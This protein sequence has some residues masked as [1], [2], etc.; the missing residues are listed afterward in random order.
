MEGK[1]DKLEN[2]VQKLLKMAQSRPQGAARYRGGNYQRERAPGRGGWDQREW[3][4][5]EECFACG[6][7]GH[8]TKDCMN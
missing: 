8:F 1:I 4:R 6:E 3:I 2:L 7:K 5:D